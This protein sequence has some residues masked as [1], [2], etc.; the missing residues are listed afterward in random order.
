[1]KDPNSTGSLD[2]A[3]D[4]CPTPLSIEALLTELVLV[5]NEND[6]LCL[7]GPW[8][9]D[10][11]HSHGV[12]ETLFFSKNMA[13]MVSSLEKRS[14]GL[15][16]VSGAD[17]ILLHPYLA[18]TY[19]AKGLLTEIPLL[20]MEVGHPS[21]WTAR[22]DV[23]IIWKVC[24]EATSYEIECFRTLLSTY[25]AM[26][27]I[28]LS[29][30]HCFFYIQED[31]RL[32]YEKEIK[33]SENVVLFI[34]QLIQFYFRPPRP[35][36]WSIALESVCKAL[37]LSLD[38]SSSTHSFKT[39]L[40][41]NGRHGK[42]WQVIRDNQQSSA[43]LALKVVVG[44]SAIDLHLEY[45]NLLYLSLCLPNDVVGVIET[46]SY[47]QGFLPDGV[48]PYAAYLMERGE[49]IHRKHMSSAQT[50]GLLQALH[51]LH[52]GGFLHGSCRCDNAI[53][54]GHRVK[55]IDLRPIL[56]FSCGR[57]LS[58]QDIYSD[59]YALMKDI[60]PRLSQE[61]RSLA[62]LD[63]YVDFMMMINTH[64][65]DTWWH[66]IIHKMKWQSIR[67]ELL[68]IINGD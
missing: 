62:R 53:V 44:S 28:L 7:L 10:I 1:M 18:T 43:D 19:S 52:A 39:S 15:S 32:L 68:K 2:G 63:R 9:A 16:S 4:N 50:A 34:E 35:I 60:Y 8:L 49:S 5:D 17:M 51:H 30:R 40:I 36:S 27:G 42:V 61:P 31:G 23:H 56:H 59:I 65:N 3:S 22:D 46:Q 47:H 54:V 67:L 48:T 21:I 64:K 38:Y 41:G 11:L 55:W 24:M 29:Q 6:L 57:K 13:K 25:H 37:R 33:W 45:E 14:D 12:Q 26:K 66:Q 20:Y 58:A